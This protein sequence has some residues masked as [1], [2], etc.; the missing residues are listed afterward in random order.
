MSFFYTKRT[1]NHCIAKI[2]AC[3]DCSTIHAQFTN[4]KEVETFFL[5]VIWLRAE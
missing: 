1:P 4:P 5:V 2:T 3:E